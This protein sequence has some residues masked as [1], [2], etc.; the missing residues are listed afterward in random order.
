MMHENNTL[1]AQVS[2]LQTDNTQLQDENR[3]DANHTA[4]CIKVLILCS[5]NACC[6]Q[7]L[8]HASYSV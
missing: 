8:T 7:L 3:Q 6:L 5:A 1:L 4:S 2:S